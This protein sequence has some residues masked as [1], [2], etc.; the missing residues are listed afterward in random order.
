MIRTSETVACQDLLDDK[1]ERL[2]ASLTTA[3]DPDLVDQLLDEL[4]LLLREQAATPAEFW[5]K[6]SAFQHHNQQLAGW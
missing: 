4:A 3:T 2:Q 5:A 1:I 6:R